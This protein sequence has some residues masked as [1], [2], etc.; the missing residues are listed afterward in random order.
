MQP[1]MQRVPTKTSS[2]SFL[3]QESSDGC[4]VVGIK[5]LTKGYSLAVWTPSAVTSN[6]VELAIAISPQ[7]RNLAHTPKAPE[8]KPQ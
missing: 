4:S 5:S 6:C 8:I 3:T 2:D 1:L 7:G